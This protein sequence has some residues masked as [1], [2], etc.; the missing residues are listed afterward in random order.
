[1]PANLPAEAKAKYAKYLDARTI[2]EKI[3]ALEEFISAVPKHKG[4]ENLLYWARRRLAELRREEEKRKRSRKG[5]GPGLFVEKEG[6]AQIVV[7]GLPNAGK[8]SIVSELTNAKT[9]IADYPLS[10]VRPVPGM[11]PYEDV[12]FQL[13]DSPPLLERK[14]SEWNRRVAGLV[15]NA[16][17][18]IVVLSADSDPVAQFRSIERLLRDE[19][20]L[21]AKPKGRVM[22]EK[23]KGGGQGI[24]IVLSGRI[25]GGTVEDVRKLLNSYRIYAALV[26]IYGEVTLDDVERALFEHTV[27]K[28]GLTLLNKVDLLDE[29]SLEKLIATIKAISPY[30]VLPVSARR[31]LDAKL[32]GRLLFEQLE[33]VRVYTKQPNAEPSKEPL[34]LKKGATV[35]DVAKAI[36]SK[37]AETFRYAKIWGPS[38]KYPGERVGPEH[39]VADGDV[40]E[41]HVKG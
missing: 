13:I 6:A 28:P 12:R 2:G 29:V 36:H 10:T 19:G 31:G 4:T 30:P 21:L 37:F 15:R 41:I 8:S 16:D 1:M 22:I 24:R 20:V 9:V 7:V 26:K 27:Y 25:I 11:M 34:I 18:I 14:G 5:G 33:I 40:V 38:A 39:V 32:I 17:G 23:G 35:L 3:K